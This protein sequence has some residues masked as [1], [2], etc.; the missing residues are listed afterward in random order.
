MVAV[1][2]H[3]HFNRPVDEFQQPLAED[4]LPLLASM[5]GFRGFY[6]VREA[7]DRA[8]VIILWENVD[9]AAS[10]AMKFGPGW[11]NTNLAPHLASEQVRSAGEVLLQSAGGLPA[12]T[13]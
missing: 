10:G 11:F 6:F 8:A 7:K 3:L 13:E 9:S 1:I 4:G 5:P 2:N 12:T